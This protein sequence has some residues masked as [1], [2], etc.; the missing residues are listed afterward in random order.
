MSS[1]PLSPDPKGQSSKLFLLLPNGVF[2][3]TPE[4]VRYRSSGSLPQLLADATQRLKLHSSARQAFTQDGHVVRSLDALEPNTVLIISCGEPMIQPGSPAALKD[5]FRKAVTAPVAPS[6]PQRDSPRPD[7]R[8]SVADSQ[9]TAITLS[10]QPQSRYARY[11]QLLVVLP[12]SV[13]DQIRE[14]MLASYLAMDDASQQAIE[15]A[16][17]YD[18]MLKNRRYH[19]FTEQMLSEGIAATFSTS[20]I[21]HELEEWAVKRLTEVPIQEIRAVITGP[22]S[23]GRTLLLSSLG[24]VLYR[25]IQNSDEADRHLVFPFNCKV[26]A[27]AFS[28]PLLLY[29]V[30][31]SILFNSIRSAKFELLPFWLPLR[32][33]LLCAATIGTVGKLPTPLLAQGIVDGAALAQLANQVHAAFHRKA[34]HGELLSLILGLPHALAVALK[35]RTAAYIID[36]LDAAPPEATLAFGLAVEHSPFIAVANLSRDFIAAFKQRNYE[37]IQTRD[38]VS[39]DYDEQLLLPD[40]QLRLRIEDMMGCPGYVCAFMRICELLACQRSHTVVASADSPIRSKINDARAEEVSYEVRQ[41]VVVLAEA[42]GPAVPRAMAKR[43][44][45][46]LE[47]R[48]ASHSH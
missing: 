22:A 11:H 42:G 35:M 44:D 12:G 31:V 37:E 16:A 2:R 29:S 39:V 46:N 13:E 15:G 27:S 24:S 33:W 10:S 38:V 6:S 20:P 5:R 25:F 28:D 17:I 23:S 36:G 14:S 21:D 7:S 47:V 26:H 30:V 19:L 1:A 48:L 32:E 41:L 3:Q 18:D 8:R 45:A 9:M 4:P 40:L 34:S 43:L